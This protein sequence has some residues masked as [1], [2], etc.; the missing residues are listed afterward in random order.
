MERNESGMK[1]KNPEMRRAT[2]YLDS[3]PRFSR[4]KHSPDKLRRM[5]VLLDE[6]PGE[7]KIVHVAGTNGKGS[8]CAFLDSVLRTAGY[9]T[10]MFV[11][12]HLVSVRERFIFDGEKAEEAC[13]LRAFRKIRS[14]EAEFS[15]EG[16]SH[17][18]YFEFLFLMFMSM[19]REKNPE[20]VI[21]E[22][23]L[24]G[25]LDATNC[26]EHPAVSVITSISLDHMEYLGDTIE[27]I[28]GEKAG[29][30][31]TGVPVVYDNTVPEAAEVIKR[32]A[33]ELACRAVPVGEN[34]W[35]NGRLEEDG[36]SFTADLGNG[37]KRLRISFVALYQLS[38]AMLAVRTAQLM[39]ISPEHIAEG[40]SGTRWPGRMEPVGDRVYFDGAHNEG[41]IQAFARAAREI[42]ARKNPG[43]RVILVFAVAS[44]KDYTAMI[45]TLCCSLRPDRMI[46]T[47]ANSDRGLSL[48]K[49]EK[50]AADGLAAEQ[51]TASERE[52]TGRETGISAVSEAAAAFRL[53]LSEQRSEDTVFCAGS[54][55]LIG[56]L[57]SVLEEEKDER[58]RTDD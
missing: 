11:S 34:D 57:K 33:E 53:A 32:R 45:R 29:I 48:E 7:E 44:D 1:E 47:R 6:E 36:I 30:I 14:R 39:G 49:L 55:Y 12:P 51:G 31:K 35:E 16:L 50:A 56:E 18:T 17:P 24:G 43:G 28:A 26:L 23:G 13:F 52:E 46:L 19:V 54:L 38:N 8:V 2:E 42:V 21:L 37:P 40:I 27:Q 22:T 25:R 58:G 15:R 41:G 5:L 9:K 10:A 20:F 3:I 4:E